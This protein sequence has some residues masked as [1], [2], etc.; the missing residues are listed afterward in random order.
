ML[1]RWYNKPKKE[2]QNKMNYD[3][4]HKLP[5]GTKATPMNSLHYPNRTPAA[6]EKYRSRIGSLRRKGVSNLQIKTPKA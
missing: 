5:D 1:A 4:N 6:E 3:P 2:T